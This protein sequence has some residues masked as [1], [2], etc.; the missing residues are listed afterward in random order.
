[1][2]VFIDKERE[3]I[4]V[5]VKFMLWEFNFSIGIFE[6][7]EIFWCKIEIEFILKKYLSGLGVLGVWV[8][9]GGVGKKS[10]E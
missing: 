3:E 2:W 9:G 1:M 10:V 6:D 4:D 7:V 5:N 8:F